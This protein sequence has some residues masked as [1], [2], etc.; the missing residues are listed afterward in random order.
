VELSAEV[1][2]PCGMLVGPTCQVIL[3]VEPTQL[4]LTNKR[5]PCGTSWLSW[6][7]RELPCGTSVATGFFELA[8]FPVSRLHPDRLCPQVV[9][10]ET[11]DQISALD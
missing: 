5:V 11:C 6:P 4:R 10:R 3:V 2:L 1:A 9:P 7:N 8:P